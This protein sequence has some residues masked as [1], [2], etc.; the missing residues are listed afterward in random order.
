[1][2][3]ITP[4][5][6]N[7]ERRPAKPALLAGRVQQ[8]CRDALSALGTASTSDVIGFAYAQRLIIG[9]E[10]RKNHFS[11]AVRH[12]LTRRKK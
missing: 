7:L 12:A 10:R 11:R 9:G 4:T 5:I 6:R 1:M 2:R 3:R 8:A